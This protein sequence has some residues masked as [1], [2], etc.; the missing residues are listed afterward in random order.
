MPSY[1]QAQQGQ[2][3]DQ[4][5]QPQGKQK[6]D[7]K[8]GQGQN[9]GQSQ[10][11]PATGG[12][13]PAKPPDKPAPLFGGSLNL[14]SSRQSKDVA[15]LGFNGLDPNG[16]VQKGFLTSSATAADTAKAQQLSRSGVNQADLAAFLQEGNLGP[17]S[18]PSQN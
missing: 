18:A 10:N 6:K 7:P 15:T 2:A 4:Q 8:K 16:Q 3:D 11:P 14:K 9:Q 17:Q 5:A 13:Q 12:A 1:Q